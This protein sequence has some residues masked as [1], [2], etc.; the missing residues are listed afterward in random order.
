MQIACTA[1][2]K[3]YK[4]AEVMMPYKVMASGCITNDFVCSPFLMFSCVDWL[5]STLLYTK[6][7]L[8]LF[9]FWPFVEKITYKLLITGYSLLDNG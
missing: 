5:I 9:N 8:N 4:C 3:V 6:F 7:V 1:K 2:Q